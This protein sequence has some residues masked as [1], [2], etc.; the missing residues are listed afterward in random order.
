MLAVLL[1]VIVPDKV[2]VVALLISD[3]VAPLLRVMALLMLSEVPLNAIVA[4]LATVAVALLFPKPVLFATVNVPALTVVVPVK[5]FAPDR[6]KVPVPDEFTFN[7]FVAEPPEMATVDIVKVSAAAT[8][9]VSLLL[10]VLST[11]IPPV[12]ASPAEPLSFKVLP[13]LRV[14][15]LAMT[16][17]PS[18][19]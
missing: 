10:A 3:S 1:N 4:P 6:I 2:L 11:V 16:R 18:F 19:Q 5:V 15:A 9:M 17:S 14:I 8:L 7:V 13:L 12:N